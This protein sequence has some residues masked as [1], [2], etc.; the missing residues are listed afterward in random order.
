VA[1]VAGIILW[2]LLAIVERAQ[3]LIL[4]RKPA[5]DAGVWFM[6]TAQSIN[7]ALPRIAK[8]ITSWASTGTDFIT[9]ALVPKRTLGGMCSCLSC[10]FGV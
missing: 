1:E 2:D 5:G 6:L 8:T 9:M 10:P 4:T 7:L 3:W